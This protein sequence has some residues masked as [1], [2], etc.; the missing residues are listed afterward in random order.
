MN[1]THNFVIGL[2]NGLLGSALIWGLIA[3]WLL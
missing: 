1:D 2:R 3:W